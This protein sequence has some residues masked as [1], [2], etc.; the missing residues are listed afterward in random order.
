MNARACLLLP[1]AQP[2]GRTVGEAGKCVQP[3]CPGRGRSGFGEELCSSSGGDR[4]P[5][6]YRT[7]E[8]LEETAPCGE[9][10]GTSGQPGGNDVLGL[11]TGEGIASVW[12]R[13]V[14]SDRCLREF[15]WDECCLRGGS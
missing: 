12:R 7:L 10:G 11:K 8:Q 1:G 14:N 13:E 6:D 5:A 4:T 15:Q 2:H 3:S 9:R